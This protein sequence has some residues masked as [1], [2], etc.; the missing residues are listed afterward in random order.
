MKIHHVQI[1]QILT[2]IANIRSKVYWSLQD[3]LKQK[4]VKTN[5]WNLL[6]LLIV[7]ISQSCKASKNKSALNKQMWKHL[8]ACVSLWL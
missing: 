4:H 6:V 3:F 1:Q 7:E 5:I 2:G 8:F